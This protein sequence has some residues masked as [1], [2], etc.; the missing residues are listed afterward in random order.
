MDHCEKYKLPPEL[1]DRDDAAAADD[2][3]HYGPVPEA[4]KSKFAPGAVYEG[5]ELAS[6]ATLGAGVD[7]FA[8]ARA[9]GGDEPQTDGWRRLEAAD[10]VAAAAKASKK[11]KHDRKDESKRDKK[12]KKD[13][14]KKK[15]KEKD[16]RKEKRG[17]GGSA[18][19]AVAGD[20]AMP[21]FGY[22]PEKLA[23]PAEVP[24]AQE[25]RQ[26][27]VVAPSWRG[28]REPGAP[29]H[30]GARFAPSRRDREKQKAQ[31]APPPKRS[32]EEVEKDRL[33]SYGGASRLR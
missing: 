22:V 14:K 18:A 16:G 1:R 28:S 20:D 29:S 23:A 13:K 25:A 30:H 33:K 4:P 27:E 2:E 32:W 26:G 3:G 5:K 7:V 31:Q 11:R 6:S 24:L 9:A 17:R 19:A 10:A 12:D 21:L 15:D 8:T